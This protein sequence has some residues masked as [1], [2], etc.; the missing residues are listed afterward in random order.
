[1]GCSFSFL[2]MS[3]VEIAKSYIGK[4]EK[5]SNSGFNDKVFESKMEEVGF[6]KGQAWLQVETFPN[7]M[8]SA[9][10]H[11]KTVDYNH[12]GTER[13]IKSF[14]NSYGYL[15]CNLMQNGIRKRKLI[16]RLVAEAFIP[17]PMNL[18]TVNH[19]DGNKLNN[20]VDNL[21]WMSIEDN[22]RDAHTQGLVRYV[23]GESHY[24]AIIPTEEIVKIKSL[25]GRNIKGRDIAKQFGVSE[26][27]I[28]S[29][30]TGRS[31]KHENL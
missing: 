6:Q 25:L 13:M 2:K 30:K 10:G 28:S 23:N 20:H 9:T 27:Y 18:P 12:T 16:H 29:I 24:K 14:V 19:K 21:E 17:N 15:S 31:R 3:V 26:K 22:T 1:M 5:P 7:Y 4:T 11:I 8:V